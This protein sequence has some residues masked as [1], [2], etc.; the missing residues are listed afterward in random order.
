MMR[1]IKIITSL[2]IGYCFGVKRAMSLINDGLNNSGCKLYSIGAVIH[3]PQAVQNL[4]SRGVIQI[5]SID[6][7]KSGD[8]MIIRAHGVAPEIIEKC[9]KRGIKLID[10][11]C[12]FVKRIHE[13]VKQMPGDS[14][15]IIIIGDAKHPEVR[16]IAGMARDNAIIIE[17]IESAGRISGIE[18]AGVVIQTTFSR[19]ESNAIIE[20]LKERID[21]IRVHDTICEATTLR[22][23]ATLKLA[24]EVDMILVVGGKDSSNTR[25]LYQM[26]LDHDIPARFIETISE[27]DDSWFEGFSKIGLATGTS[28]P[29]WII[30]EVLARL[31][32]TQ[33]SP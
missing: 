32:E 28:T 5:S 33:E 31:S 4:E 17:S 29:D 23:E 20:V 16:G 10:T 2:H 11:T 13:Y 24:E 30:G 8:T 15:S 1:K 26:C 27:I 14:R 18:K 12:P 22:R 6:E 7:L 25:R 3:N 9:V 19:E 21:D